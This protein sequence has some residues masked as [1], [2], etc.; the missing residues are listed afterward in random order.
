M[1][2][3]TKYIFLLSLVLPFTTAHAV[4][5]ADTVV[6]GAFRLPATLSLPEGAVA[7]VVLVH[8]SGPNDRDETIMACHPFKDIAEGLSSRGIAVL[9]YDKRTFVYKE[10]SVEEG[11]ELTIDDEVTDDAIAAVEHLKKVLGGKPVFVAGHSLGAM[12]APRIA[13]QCGDV[14]GVILLAAP[15][16]DLLTLVGEQIRYLMGEAAND[17]VVKQAKEQVKRAAPDSYW[18]S[19]ASYD[20]LNTAKGLTVPILQIHGGRDYQVPMGDFYMWSMAM[21]GKKG[22]KQ[23]LYPTLNHLMIAGEGPST[24]QEYEKQGTVAEEVIEAITSFVNETAGEK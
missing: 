17:M 16:R 2:T 21:M 10:K 8:G 12:M 23:L 4:E 11:K 3:L 18:Q 7:G 5:I 6:S 19:L 13:K 14:S 24:P 22:Y 20:Q 15:A 9:R 1:R